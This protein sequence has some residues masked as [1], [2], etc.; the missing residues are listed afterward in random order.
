MTVEAVGEEGAYLSSVA[1]A[2][3]NLS[4]YVEL[5]NWVTLTHQDE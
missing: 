3:Y 4:M 1:V 2:P 5:Y